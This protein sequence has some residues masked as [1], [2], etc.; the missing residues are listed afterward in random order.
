MISNCL[1]V[2]PE[3]LRYIAL[4]FGASAIANLPKHTLTSNGTLKESGVRVQSCLFLY[5]LK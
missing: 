2:L 5:E 3:N 4:K 1:A